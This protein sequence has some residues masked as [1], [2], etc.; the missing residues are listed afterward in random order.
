MYIQITDHCNMSCGHCC[1]SCSPRKKNFMSME[2]FSKALNVIV[3][4]GEYV[5]IGGGEP[6]CHPEFWHM[7]IDAIASDAEGVWLATNGKN[8]KDAL[9]LA[10]LAKKNVID[11]E[12]SQDEW[13]DPI[14]QRVVSAFRNINGRPSFRT[15]TKISKSGR[16]KNISG[17]KNMCPCEDIFIDPH[18]NVFSCGCKKH[19][20]GTVFDVDH[21][22][23]AD[24]YES[25][26]VGHGECAFCK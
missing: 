8:T 25:K 16:G 20:F 7:L 11:C 10:G 23:I 22:E 15:V 24:W 19:K 13:H 2:T 12:L 5:S 21:S 6:T 9:K 26:N 3:D 18:G 1:Y 14:D 4:Y 17:S